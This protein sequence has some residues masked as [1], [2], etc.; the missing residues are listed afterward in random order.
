MK[1]LKFYGIIGNAYALIKSYLSDRYQQVCIDDKFSEWGQVTHGVPQGSIL[2]PVLFILYINELSEV[3]NYNSEPVLFADDT[4][5]IVSDP[6]LLNFKNNLISSFKQL[7]EWFDINF[8]SLNY[9]R[10]EYIHFRTTKSQTIQL[11]ISYNN[12]CISNGI[13]AW[14]LGI[15]V[16][17]LLSW[18]HHVDELMAKLSKECYAIRSF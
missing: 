15:T 16:D 10:T 18:K 9:N 12:R 8:L 2:G 1:K 13:N 3:V 14:F 6:N 4:S 17:S 5:V 11:D 7:N